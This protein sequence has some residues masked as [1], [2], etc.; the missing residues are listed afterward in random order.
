VPKFGFSYETKRVLGVCV[1]VCVCVCVLL[2]SR[3]VVKESAINRCGA[4]ELS[5][6]LFWF[7][8]GGYRI[9]EANVMEALQGCVAL[10]SFRDFRC[11][12]SY[13]K[14]VTIC[15]FFLGGLTPR[16]GT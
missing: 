1:C 12:Y 4:S 6:D 14:S 3:C 16:G 9:N 15:S 2:S 7:V 8:F 13:S 11:L 10:V 5:T